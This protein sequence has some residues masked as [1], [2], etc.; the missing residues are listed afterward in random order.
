MTAVNEIKERLGHYD[1]DD[2]N[3]FD[4][5][6][7]E[8]KWKKNRQMLEGDLESELETTPFETYK[9]FRG[10]KNSILGLKEVGIFKGIIRVKL[11]DSPADVCFDDN[12]LKQLLKP[13]GYKI[14][15]YVLEAKGLTPMDVDMYGKPSKSDPYLKVK[16][17]DFKFDDR[18][19]AIDDVV[20][21]DFYKMIEMDAELPGTS[22][23]IIDVMDKDTIGYDDLIGSTV[24]DLEDRWFDNRWQELGKEFRV[25]PDTGNINN[26]RWVL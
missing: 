17:G 10:K 22:Q 26:I 16:L 4:D 6:E 21:V 23:L 18:V 12:L 3:I 11:T 9:L 15:L 7:T 1:D 5:E 25:M 19:N 2:D 14:R 24:I 8:P 13:K 20:D